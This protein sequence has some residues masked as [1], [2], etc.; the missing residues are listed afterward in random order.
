[1]M[2]AVAEQANNSEFKLE[3]FTYKNNI[4]KNIM[5]RHL[6]NTDFTGITVWHIHASPLPLFLLQ[7][8]YRVM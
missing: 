4:V 6:E 1:M 7:F 8:S 3:L 5:F 2:A